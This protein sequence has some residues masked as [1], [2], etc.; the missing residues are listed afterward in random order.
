MSEQERLTDE[1]VRYCELNPGC[2]SHDVLVKIAAE[3]RTS[4]AE[5]VPLRKEVAR[6]G[7]AL[8][9]MTAEFTRRT[10]LFE[11]CQKQCVAA[12][13]VFAASEAAKEICWEIEANESTSPCGKCVECARETANEA[14]DAS[15]KEAKDA[16]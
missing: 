15:R 8:E 2:T 13:A 3:L 9:N 16:G 14:Y 6:L 4:R 11:A 1:E 12:D 5:C 10:I 7:D